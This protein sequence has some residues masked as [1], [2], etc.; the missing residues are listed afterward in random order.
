MV[1]G[2]R[3]RMYQNSDNYLGYY[4]AE[5]K[6]FFYEGNNLK[7]N[8]LFKSEENALKFDSHIRSESKTIGS[9][10]NK[11]IINVNVTEISNIPLG[12]RI[13]YEDYVATEFESPESTFSQITAT[14][15][16]FENTS[17]IFKFQRIEDINVF[18]S[19]GKAESCHLISSSHCRKYKSYELYDN[20]PNNRLA[21]SRDLHGWFAGLNIEIPLFCL[22]IISISESISVSSRYQVVLAVQ[23][24]DLEYA[25]K[26]FQR[27]NNGSQKTEDPLVMDT[28]VY[29]TDP[30]VFQNCLNWKEKNT[31]KAWE[32]Y[33]SVE[34]AI[35]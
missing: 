15:S 31:K 27:L 13:Y 21:M 12:K 25:E 3:S 4:E 26:I 2:V 18:G 19:K 10:L 16:T 34:S 28:V 32:T 5:K 20:N 24:F 6:A 17:D 9:S 8:V 33:F 1:K 14:Y 23:A 35:P 11:L 30:T 22:S 29:V 7:I